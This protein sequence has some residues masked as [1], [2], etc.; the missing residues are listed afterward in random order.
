MYV[1]GVSII[2]LGDQSWT[3][4]SCFAHVKFNVSVN[5]DQATRIER[6]LHSMQA[7]DTFLTPNLSQFVCTTSI[8][9][10]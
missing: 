9:V 8:R 1:E 3:I 10:L 5:T 4:A 7:Q 2:A 6:S